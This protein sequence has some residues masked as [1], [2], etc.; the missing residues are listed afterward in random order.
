MLR[1][2]ALAASALLFAAVGHAATPGYYAATPA[3]Q[4]TKASLMTHATPWR[5]QN[6]AYIAD[7]APER[8]EVLCQ[9]VARD[10]G[11]LSGFTAGGAGFDADALA[12]CNAHAR[13]A[14]A[15]AASVAAR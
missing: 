6:G 1:V 12:Q 15:A 4:P 11:Q 3:A 5:L 13:G 14:P 8:A 7:R 10:V 9:L 2:T